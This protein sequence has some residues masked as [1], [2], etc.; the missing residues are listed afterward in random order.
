MHSQFYPSTPTRGLLASRA[1]RHASIWLLSLV[2]MFGLVVGQTAEAGAVEDHH[3]ELSVE[4]DPVAAQETASAPACHPSI[5]CTAFVLP[6][7]PVT[8]LSFSPAIVLRP[9]VTQSQR[10]FGGPSITLP[11]PRTLT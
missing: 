7:G 10:R 3:P 11:P 8:L 2:M 6:K 1:L 5:A 9:D 4:L